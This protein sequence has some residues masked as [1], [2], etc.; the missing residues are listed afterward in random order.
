MELLALYKAIKKP[1]RSDERD[2][3][4]FCGTTA[5][6]AVNKGNGVSF[7]IPA[8]TL[9]GDTAYVIC[10]ADQAHNQLSHTTSSGVLTLV[11]WTYNDYSGGSR[12]GMYVYTL[13]GYNK[14]S[15]ITI[16]GGYSSAMYNLHIV[17]N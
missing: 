15:G 17:L 4:L 3:E 13:N 9:N 14:A 5:Y 7:T 6:A 16:S 11:D 12:Y 1:P 2:G 8:N 10:W